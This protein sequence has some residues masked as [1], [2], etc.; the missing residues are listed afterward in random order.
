MLKKTSDDIQDNI[1]WLLLKTRSLSGS[2][3]QDG[4]S[5]AFKY[6]LQWVDRGLHVLPSTL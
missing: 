2:T 6:D 4:I 3:R 1:I 5:P